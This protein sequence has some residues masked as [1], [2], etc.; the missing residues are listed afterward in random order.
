MKFGIYF[1]IIL[2]LLSSC[3][4]IKYRNDTGFQM[5]VTSGALESLIFVDSKP[6]KDIDGEIGLCSK[7]LFKD[8]SLELKI[9]PHDYNYNLNLICSKSINF[10][11]SID[12][13]KGQEI[14]IVIE[15]DNYQHVTHFTCIGEILPMDRGFVSH[16]FEVRVRLIDPE[17]V[18]RNEITVYNK[19][20]K[21]Y[22]ILGQYSRYSQ[23]YRNNKWE[24]YDRKT[25]LKIKKDE[26]N[27][28]KAMSESESG[29]MT[30]YNM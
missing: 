12:V 6:C 15:E 20:R 9:P 5:P 17:Y 11:R 22:L 25:V 13:L 21:Y 23:V 4:N 8:R 27:T 24:Y 18:K 26:I 1:S 29:R 14:E 2:F 28:I 3:T 7:R 30:Y 16:K 10:N 19:G